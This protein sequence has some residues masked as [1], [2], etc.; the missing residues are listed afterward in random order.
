MHFMGELVVHR[1]RVESLAAGRR[2]RGPGRG[3]RRPHPQLPGAAGARDAGADDRGRRR[4]HALP[5]A[6]ARPVR[7]DRQAGRPG[8][9]RPRDRAR[10]HRR[11]RPR[12]PARAPRAQLARPRPRDPRRARGRRQ[13]ARPAC[14]SSPPAR[15]AATS[16]SPSATTAA[17]S[18]PP[19]SPR[20]AAERG[21]I[22]RRRGR[23]RSTW[24]G[25]SSSL[26]AAG[27]STAEQTS[28]ISGRGVGMDAVRT[29]LR[30]A[31]RRRRH[32]LR[33]GRR[34]HRPGAPAADA[35]DHAGAARR[36]AARCR[37]P[38]RSSGSSARSTSPSRR[39]AR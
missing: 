8:P 21:L 20:K 19:G 37:S 38:S 2:D 39:C 23:R 18:I 16:S 4:L 29:A 33:A 26:F 34:H 28:D 35:R 36:V 14:S 5:P 10:P 13:A 27:F 17:A 6:R 25:R 11:R 9:D 3:G 32:D 24:P 22:A 12:R 15:P 31:R 30:G 7:Q 1:T